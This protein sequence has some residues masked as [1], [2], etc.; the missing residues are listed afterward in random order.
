[1]TK[2]EELAKE[3]RRQATAFR[4]LSKLMRTGEPDSKQLM[5]A[6]VAEGLAEVC[7]GLASL[8]EVEG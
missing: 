5:E 6:A 8:K 4:T 1:M 7:D 3:F 2:A